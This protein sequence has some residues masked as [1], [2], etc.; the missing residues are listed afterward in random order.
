MSKDKTPHKPPQ[1]IPFKQPSSIK[2]RMEKGNHDQ[3][4]YFRPPQS[5]KPKPK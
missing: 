5:P 1:Q 4:S 2:K 3:N